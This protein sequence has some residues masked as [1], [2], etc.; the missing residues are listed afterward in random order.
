LLS[1]EQQEKITFIKGDITNFEQIRDSFAQHQVNQVIHLAALQVP[2]CRANP[3]LGAQV[4][5]VGTVNIFEAARQT[6]IQHLAYASSIAVY[7]AADDYPAGLLSANA[8]MLPRTLYGVY[9]VSNE[10][11]ARIYWQDHKISSTVLRPYTVYGLGRDQGLT[12]EA[13]K[14]M[15]AASQGQNYHIA[16]GGRMQFHYASDVALQFIVAAQT[17]LDG[18]KGFN[19]GTA[20]VAV[21]EMAN[22]IMAIVPNVSIT[23]EETPLP[24]PEGCDPAPLHAAFTEIYETPLRAG[25]EKTILSFRSVLA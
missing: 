1:A 24:F 5:V 23:V 3:V 7:G 17:P 22:L 12:S 16:F 18:A 9:K 25:I 10:A 11:T 6:G 19:L 20:P 2:M 15:Q 13:T 8:P 4:N 14:A 21:Q